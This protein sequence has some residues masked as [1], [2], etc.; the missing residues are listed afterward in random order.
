MVKLIAL[1]FTG[2]HKISCKI[3]LSKAENI[4]NKNKGIIN[5]LNL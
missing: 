1:K 2:N 5:F 4:F 3:N